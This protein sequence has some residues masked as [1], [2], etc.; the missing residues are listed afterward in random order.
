MKTGFYGLSPMLDEMMEN[1]IF[2]EGTV[3]YVLQDRAEQ[4][5]KEN[6][7]R[8]YTPP[9][10]ENFQFN[11]LRNQRPLLAGIADSIVTPD[12]SGLEKVHAVSAFTTGMA[13]QYP[14]PHEPN[15]KAYPS[16]DSYFWGGTEEILITKGTDWCGEVARVFCALTQMLGI[17]SRII[18]TY[19]DEDGHVI[20]EC[21][22][23][24]K[25]L[26]VDSTVN[27]V[28]AKD[29]EWYNAGMLFLDKA[30][31]EKFA[32]ERDWFYC[33]PKFFKYVAIS[34]YALADAS[35]YSYRISFC[36]DYYRKALSMWNN[37]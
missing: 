21:F 24:G 16:A 33:A 1:R 5:D 34:E 17:P 2:R 22:V 28:Y 3:D 37:E 20:N 6:I 4:L 25:W 9:V 8:L 12:M 27:I 10:T 15:E 32:A 29:G 14:I 26:L 23:D 19:S 11:K 13:A 36:N 30:P 18:Y 31:V 35:E 7:S